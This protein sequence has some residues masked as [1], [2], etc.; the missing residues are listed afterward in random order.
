MAA[1][2]EPPGGRLARGQLLQLGGQA[3]IRLFQRGHPVL[4]RRRLADQLGRPGVQQLGA[5]SAGCRRRLRP[6][7]AG[8]R[9]TTGQLGSSGDQTTS[10]AATA[11]SIAALGEL[12]S[13]A[14]PS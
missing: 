11:G 14:W 9:I 12:I 4:P 10:P 8:S 6:G 2:A 3:L 5:W 7:P 13:A 1:S